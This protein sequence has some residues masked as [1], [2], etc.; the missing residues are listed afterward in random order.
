MI[1]WKPATQTPEHAVLIFAAIED[2]ATHS[3]KYG[4][5]WYN[6]LSENPWQIVCFYEKYALPARNDH[7]KHRVAGWVYSDEKGGVLE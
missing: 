3:I 7:E 2:K 1:E 6:K 4:M 5:G